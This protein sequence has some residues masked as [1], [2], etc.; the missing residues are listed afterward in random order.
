M[1]P[2][3]ARRFTAAQLA[4]LG[5]AVW[6]LAVRS[7]ILREVGPIGSMHRRSVDYVCAN[8]QARLYDAVLDTL[9][10]EEADILRR[11]RNA[12]AGPAPR[13]ASQEE[14]GKAT[15]IEA[16]VGYWHLSGRDDCV[17]ALLERAAT[18]QRGE[19]GGERHAQG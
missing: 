17:E 7:R 11:G 1:T 15:A 16:L 9:D 18:L 8:A 2:V 3:E 12:H 5:D 13:G 14:Y 10:E 19:T 6:S 4:F